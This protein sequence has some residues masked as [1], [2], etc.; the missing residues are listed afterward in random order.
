MSQMRGL[1]NFISEIR[2]CK[3]K[4]LEKNRV[5]RELSNI[6]SKFQKGTRLDAYSRRK[7]TWKLIYIYMLGY[8]IDIGHMEAMQLCAARTYAEK[9]TGYCACQTLFNEKHDLLT[10]LTQPVIAMI[11]HQDLG[12]ALCAVTLM[13]GLLSLGE[14]EA[15]EEALPTTVSVL[16]K[17]VHKN[18]SGHDFGGYYYFNTVSPWLQMKCLRL[19]QYFPKPTGEVKSRLDDSLLK[20]IKQETKRQR[21][22][23]QSS[24]K[25]NKT[26][27]DHGILFEAMN[28]IVYYE[29]GVATLEESKYR[30]HL[31]SMTKLLGRFI[32][33]KEANVRYLGLDAMT[34]LARIEGM[35]DKISNQ[36]TTILFSLRKDLDASIRKRALDLL[37]V[38]CNKENSRKITQE[39]LSFLKVADYK[40]REELVLKIAILAERFASDLR[41]YLDVVLKLIT[42]AGDYVT[43]DI[44]YRAIQ[45][46]INNENLQKYAAYTMFKALGDRSIHE[47]GVKVGSYI[48]GEFSDLI[49]DKA[50][51]NK[52]LQ[53]L[54]MHFETATNR[55]KALVLSSYIKLANSFPD[56]IPKVK[57]IM[58][59]YTVHADEELQQRACEYKAIMT[60]ER[61]LLE[62]LFELMPAFENSKGKRKKGDADDE[63]ED[64][65]D[66][67]E[68]DDEELEFD[69]QD[70]E[71]YKDFL[72]SPKDS[73]ILYKSESLQLG[74]KMITGN[75]HEV[76]MKIFYG[77]KTSTDFT[78]VSVSFD[79]PPGLEIMESPETFSVESREQKP[80]FVKIDCSRP[81][82][83]A[84][85][86]T[87]S[88]TAGDEEVKFTLTLP[89]LLHQFISPYRCDSAK[90]QENWR[91]FASGEAREI[92]AL[93]AEEETV[94]TEMPQVFHM[95]KVDM[96]SA[97]TALVGIFNALAGGNPVKLPLMGSLRVKGKQ[98]QII[99]RSKHK[100]VADAALGAFKAIYT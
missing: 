48:I 22:G 64:T 60:R 30:D 90:F 68:E 89:V 58:E 79:G 8:E 26:N 23:S 49:S 33:L 73:G 29:E 65:D 7:Y 32:S 12:V 45:I 88:F 97:A 80:Q 17:L 28:L 66:E 92:V 27:A 75:S 78:D 24:Q 91:K 3:N 52:L 2:G 21:A 94:L 86:M 4:T 10:M 41:W 46:V 56:L 63:D 98:C 51:G 67:D 74:A 15:F 34:K 44:W 62:D 42:L 57:G 5:L 11:A 61:K 70:E 40:I 16:H 6:R 38:I 93:S 18:S 43:A 36:M 1:A 31:E 47:N 37:F 95:H 53:T 83:E 50:S 71:T 55:T 96:K 69:D 84:P 77:N 14:N 100:S 35:A 20:I 81:F 19:L 9:K 13:I 54:H 85:K 39:L 82:T 25:K 59:R 99:F 76:K 87:V 72:C